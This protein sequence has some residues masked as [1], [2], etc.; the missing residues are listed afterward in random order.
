MTNDLLH[1]L[2]TN[3]YMASHSL[4]GGNKNKPAL[5][6]SVVDRLTGMVLVWSFYKLFCYVAEKISQH[7]F[8]S[9]H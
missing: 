3:E 2:Y 7:I 4:A 1:G 6:G 9:F 8:S 5:P